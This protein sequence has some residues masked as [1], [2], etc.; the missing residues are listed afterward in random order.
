MMK[1]YTFNR[2][3]GVKAVVVKRLVSDYRLDG[4]AL[5]QGLVCNL[6]SGFRISANSFF[7]LT[8]TSIFKFVLYSCWN[9][10]AARKV[11]KAGRIRYGNK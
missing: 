5:Y 10:C 4:F 7:S 1:G 6:L 9:I 2:F 8:V 11:P 3:E